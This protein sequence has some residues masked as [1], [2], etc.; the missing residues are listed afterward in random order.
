MELEW[1]EC[2]LTDGR[3]DLDLLDSRQSLVGYF[4]DYKSGALLWRPLIG[5]DVLLDG[6]TL[7]EA[8]AVAEAMVR[9]EG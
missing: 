4:V 7:D 8:K 9:L 6:L 1:A 2:T 5:S 3:A